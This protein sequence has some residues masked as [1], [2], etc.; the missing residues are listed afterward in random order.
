MAA[1]GMLSN[2]VPLS[3]TGNA[4]FAGTTLL[5]YSLPVPAGQPDIFAFQAFFM[6]QIYARGIPINGM[7]NS[8]LLPKQPRGRLSV[9]EGH[10]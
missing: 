10:P 8:E 2:V 5:H 7:T 4:D 3:P 1:I 6:S 9:D